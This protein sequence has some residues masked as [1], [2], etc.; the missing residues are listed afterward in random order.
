MPIKFVKLRFV[1]VE[2]VK[3]ILVPEIAVVDAYGNDDAIVV[4]VAVKLFPVTS[5]LEVRAPVK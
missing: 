4:D 3:R 2:L 5:P 1:D